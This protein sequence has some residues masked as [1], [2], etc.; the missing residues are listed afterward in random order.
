M[1]NL[2][3]GRLKNTRTITIFHN[4][5]NHT[6]FVVLNFLF[7]INLKKLSIK[8]PIYHLFENGMGFM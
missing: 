6:M 5:H 8:R 2:T 1:K 7:L 3:R 4:L